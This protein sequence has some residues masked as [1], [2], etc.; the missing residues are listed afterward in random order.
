MKQLNADYL[1]IGT[2]AVGMTFVDVML[3][4]SDARFIMV[5]RHHL[6]GGH[7]NDAYPFVRLHQPSAFYGAVSAD[8]GSNRID[9]TGSNKGFYELASGAEVSTYFE[10]LMRERF[11]PSGRVEYYPMCNYVGGGEFHSLLSDER[12]AVNINKK[13]V[14][15]TFF[16]TSVPSTHT[17]KFEVTD[18]I[19]CIPPNRLPRLA[20][21]FDHFTVLGGGKTATDTCVWLLDNGADP[22]SITWICPRDSWFINRESTQ[23]GIQF[24]EKAAGGF[25][26]NVEALAAATSVEDLFERMEK[27]ETMLR[28]DP[29]IMPKM[30]HYA[31]ISTGEITQLRQ[32]DKIVRG[33]RV[34]RIEADAMIMKESGETVAN[35]PNTLFIDCTARAVEFDAGITRKVFEDDLITLQPVF[36]PLVTYS[37]AVIA[38]VEVNFESEKEKNELCEPVPLA[39]TPAEWIPSTLG[40]MK[41]SFSWS[42]NKEFGR[43]INSCRLNPNA[44]AIREGAGQSADHRAIVGRIR[45]NSLPAIVNGQKLMSQQGS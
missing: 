32:I 25:A 9:E 17:R 1:V 31:T 12:Y 11:L 43:W 42:Q 23:P 10:K 22:D 19:T 38:Y 3:D 28:V 45:Q 35:R 18:E 37:A 29:T 14:D 34:A 44:A 8:L 5:D 13:T 16:N 36:A 7:W 39:D 21:D 15:G 4:L 40:N 26:N 30:F 2:G 6:P 33:Q 41:N 20:A 24:F 27:A